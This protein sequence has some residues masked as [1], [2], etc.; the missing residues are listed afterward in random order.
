VYLGIWAAFCSFLFLFVVSVFPFIPLLLLCAC[1]VQVWAQPLCSQA[2]A[3]P[4]GG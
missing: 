3:D 2:A 1:V 4:A